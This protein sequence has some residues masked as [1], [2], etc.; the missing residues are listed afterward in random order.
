MSIPGIPLE[1]AARVPG[2]VTLGIDRDR[3]IEAIRRHGP[4]R[5]PATPGWVAGM[6]AE[7]DAA[8]ATGRDL[9]ASFWY[10]LGRFPHIAGPEAAHAYA[11]HR[12]AYARA[13]KAFAEPIEML[14]IPFGTGP[15]P[16]L[17]RRPAGIARPPLALIWGGIDVWKSDLELHD[18]A[19]ALLARGVA[20]LALD[21]PGTGECP[22][23]AT[24]DATKMFQ[25][26][27][28]AMRADPRIDGAR[29]GA[30]GL[31]FGGHFALRLALA[32]PALA[33]V[34]Q[35]GGPAHLAFQPEHLGR[36][37]F[38]T[39]FALARVAGLPPNAPPERF[40]A[41]MGALSLVADGTLPPAAQAPLLSINGD[42]DEL[43]P[44]AEIDLLSAQGVRQHRLVFAGD[45]H[46]ASGHWRQ[47]TDFAADWLAAL[48]KA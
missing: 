15:I 28:A 11:L 29:I 43:V 34:V 45:R 2:F 3:V 7:G 47:H 21:G 8:A 48:L 44:I 27:L 32:E 42:A 14:A 24:P 18:M 41:A 5:G 19:E 4:E 22:V 36:L 12:A 23:V 10:F 26:V 1:L 25:A 30:Y 38:P 6:I 46:C 13:A 31:S 20:V 39:R 40:A 9:D 37:P 16:A 35:V 33:G 17:L